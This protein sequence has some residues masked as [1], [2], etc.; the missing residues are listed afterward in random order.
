[1]ITPGPAT[2]QECHFSSM[3]LPANEASPSTYSQIGF[4]I[5]LFARSAFAI[6]ATN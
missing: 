5:C 2:G 3:Y 1:M 4:L 6:Q